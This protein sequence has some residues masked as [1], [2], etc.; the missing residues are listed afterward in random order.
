MGFHIKLLTPKWR[1]LSTIKWGILTIHLSYEYIHFPGPNQICAGHVLLNAI[2][3]AFGDD[4]KSLD[5]LQMASGA[6]GGNFRAWSPTPPE[7]GSF[8]LDH[9]GE[10]TEQMSKYLQCLKFTNNQNSPN[11]RV[12]AKDYLRCRMDNQL[13]DESDWES[14]G[15]VNLPE[16]NQKKGQEE[17]THNSEKP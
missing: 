7:R 8:P 10:C 13:M 17:K 1:F 6:P 11:C 4:E 16:R 12:L 9:Y 5:K 15:L 14:L 2:V 3:V